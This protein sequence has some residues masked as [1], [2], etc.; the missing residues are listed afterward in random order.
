MGGPLI[1]LKSFLSSFPVYFLSFFM[2]PSC[3]ISSIESLLKGFFYGVVK[4][5]GRFRGWIENIFV[6]K[7][8]MVVWG[9]A[10]AGV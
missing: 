8:S 4:I 2:I 7:K 6:M 9:L 1:L 5:L 3:I 10:D